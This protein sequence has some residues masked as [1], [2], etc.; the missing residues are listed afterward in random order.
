MDVAIDGGV[1][2]LAHVKYFSP[3]SDAAK[4]LKRAL[5]LD[6]GRIR[7]SDADRLWPESK[8]QTEGAAGV[9]GGVMPD[10]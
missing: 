3:G 8:R 5:K 10:I 1:F 2:G 6:T 7:V 4:K 9:N